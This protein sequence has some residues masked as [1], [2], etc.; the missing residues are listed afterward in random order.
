[1]SI[2]I[3]YAMAKLLYLIYYIYYYYTNWDSIVI[4]YYNYINK[5]KVY[6]LYIYIRIYIFFIDW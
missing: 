3:F 4:D 2:F 1:M 6:F 5:K